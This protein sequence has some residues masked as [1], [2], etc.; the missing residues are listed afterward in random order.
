M[1]KRSY[2]IGELQDNEGNVV[3][4]HTEASVV[5]CSDGGTVQEKLESHGIK[6]LANITGVTDSTEVSNSNILATS[7]AL[8]N[9]KT[10]IV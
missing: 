1:S 9:L 10:A 2:H 3:Y 6:A 4:P 5:F 7:K 8:N